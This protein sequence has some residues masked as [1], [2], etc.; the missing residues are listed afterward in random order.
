[1]TFKI[2]GDSES[3]FVYSAKM[4]GRDISEIT[5]SLEELTREQVEAAFADY[6][7]GDAL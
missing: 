5:G 7:A 1:V 3:G 4:G 2:A 6:V